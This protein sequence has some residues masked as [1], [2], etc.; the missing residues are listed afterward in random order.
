MDD[1]ILWDKLNMPV[2]VLKYSINLKGVQ[3]FF[4][5][6]LCNHFLTYTCCTYVSFLLKDSSEPFVVLTISKL[7]LQSFKAEALKWD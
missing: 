3:R 4:A 5:V 1:Q 2:F 7:L 6:P